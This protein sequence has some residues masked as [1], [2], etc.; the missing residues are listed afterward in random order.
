MAFPILL[1]KL[2]KNGGVGPELREDILPQIPTSKLPDDYLPRGGGDVTGNLTVQSK[3]VVRSINGIDADTSGNVS[4]TIPSAYTLPTASS[5]TLG[6]VKTGSNIT[7]NSGT[8]SLSKSNVTSALGY[9]P[10]KTVNNIAVDT[11]GNVSIT[12]VTKATQ[13]GNGANIASTYLKLTGNVNQLTG[14]NA[15]TASTQT[16]KSFTITGHSGTLDETSSSGSGNVSTTTY[17]FNTLAGIA[18]G[19]YTLIQVL[20]KLINMSHTHKAS[21]GTVS[22][23]CNCDCDCACQCDD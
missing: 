11:N 9:T 20:Q 2:F 23:N 1:Q 4:V 21:K 7:N 19:N 8:I 22:S 16:Q 3:N 5:S 15:Y 17:K 18:A 14:T 13:D 10:V 6:G 12:Q